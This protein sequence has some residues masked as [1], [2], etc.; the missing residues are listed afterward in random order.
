MVVAVQLP[1]LCHHAI[2]LV[3]HI[4]A[5]G[6]CISTRRGGRIIAQGSDW[7]HAIVMA[8]WGPRATVGPAVALAMA[9]LMHVDEGEWSVKGA[10]GERVQTTYS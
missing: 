7:P 9:P 1:S 6:L 5:C 10:A 4:A 3:A 2:A 8:A